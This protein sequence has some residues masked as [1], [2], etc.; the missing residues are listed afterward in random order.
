MYEGAPFFFAQF[1]KFLKSNSIMLYIP[2]KV[3]EELNKHAKSGDSVTSKAAK[4]GI[5]IVNSWS[6]PYLET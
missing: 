5:K 2:A 6:R 3:G 1:D 4:D